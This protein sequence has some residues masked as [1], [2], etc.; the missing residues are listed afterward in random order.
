MKDDFTDI[1]F[2]G[3]DFVEKDTKDSGVEELEDKMLKLY[4]EKTFYVVQNLDKIG[5]PKKNEQIRIVTLRSFNAIAFLQWVQE[6]SGLVI[7]EALFC[8]YS[9][10]HEASVI[11]NQMVTDGR[12]KTATILM[13]NLRNKAHRQKEQMTKDYFINNPNIEL[14]FASS[15]AKI[16]SFKI[17]EDYYT[18]EGSG[19]L[20]YNSRIEQAVIDNDKSLFEFTKSWIEE[21]KIYL[22]DKKE[23]IVHK[24]L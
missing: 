18:V 6:K 20:S 23:L 7:D 13:S 9:I 5:L 15:H 22:K 3:F 12:I 19:N 10:N 11:I 21:I 2:G 24:K 17:G 14:I 8:I 16:M 1:I 4:K